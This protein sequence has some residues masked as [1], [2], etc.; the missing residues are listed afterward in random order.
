[1]IT[2]DEVREQI[3]RV[4]ILLDKAP[5]A[6]FEQELKRERAQLDYQAA[7]DIAFLTAEGTIEEKKAL[8]RQSAAELAW[9]LSVAEAE[10]NRIKLKTRQLESSNIAS[11][12]LLKSI[13]REGA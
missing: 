1:L 2:P 6:H 3:V 5:K 9:E 13:Q 11:Q 10:F 4:Q 12:A 8:A 7:Y